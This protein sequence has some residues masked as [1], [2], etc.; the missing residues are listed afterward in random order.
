MINSAKTVLALL[1]TCLLPLV[2]QAQQHIDGYFLGNSLT[3][4]VRLAWLEAIVD[5]DNP[6]TLD[7]TE[8]IV[9]GTPIDFLYNNRTAE[10]QSTFDQGDWEVATLQPYLRNLQQDIA[11]V[12]NM[13]NAGLPQNPQIQFYIYAQ[14][15]VDNGFDYSMQWLQEVSNYLA[16]GSEAGRIQPQRTQMYY[17]AL[18]EAFR[19]EVASGGNLPDGANL[20]RMIPVGHLMFVIDQLIKAGEITELTST[21]DFLIGVHAENNGMF[22]AGMTFY[23]TLFGESP[24]GLP[25]EEYQGD[26]GSTRFISPQL[27][28]TIRR[29]A[30]GVVT[31]HP[32]AGVTG[33]EPVEMLLSEIHH[34]AVQGEPFR[35]PIMAGYGPLPYGFS[36]SAGNLPPGLSLDAATGWISGTPTSAGTYGFEVTVA[37]ASNASATE[38]YEIEVEPDV[39]VS[40]GTLDFFELQAGVMAK[41]PLPVIGGNGSPTWTLQS[42]TLPLGTLKVDPAGFLSGVPSIAGIYDVTLKVEDGDSENPESDTLNVRFL[43]TP[44]PS[45]V[46]FA[47]FMEDFPNIENLTHSS[48]HVKPLNL[49]TVEGE[50]QI[51]AS[52]LLG[53]R[54]KFL[55]GLAIVDDDN[56]ISDSSDYT[57]D[58]SVEFLIDAAKNVENEFNADDRRF[59]VRY[60]SAKNGTQA[61]GT[62]DPTDSFDRDEGHVTATGYNVFFSNRYNNLGGINLSAG[63]KVNNVPVN[64]FAADQGFG[65][66]GFDLQVNDD[67]DG[68]DRDRAGVFGVGYTEGPDQKNW[69]TAILTRLYLEPFERR[70]FWV[71][72][73]VNF[74]PKASFGQKPYTWS[75]P[76][77]PA[78]LSIDP[79]TGTISGTPTTADN[80]DRMIIRVTGSDG[81]FTEWNDFV[82]IHTNPDSDGDDLPDAW[83]LQHFGNL[84]TA[85][86]AS[87]SD[88]DSLSDAV[89]FVLGLDPS[90]P[91][92]WEM[93]AEV[94]TSDGSEWLVAR[95]RRNAEY[96]MAATDLLWRSDDLESWSKVDFDGLDALLFVRDPDV[97][98]DGSVELMEARIR[99]TSSDDKM[100][101]RLQPEIRY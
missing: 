85:N 74:Q 69:K 55:F 64:G 25:L 73:P 88:S 82:S 24:E 67:D 11:G 75:A 31:G 60:T 57:H 5:G 17:E 23:A 77:L 40:T 93:K 47:P 50:G 96:P 101:V 1:S 6:N 3:A 97:D 95:W 26:G 62:L 78:G 28:Q 81:W 84:T 59:I 7:V 15:P 61:Q 54:P 2:A 10:I 70:E 87:D 65:V 19:T 53:W 9:P 33:N 30:W 36:I 83:E 79:A 49:T 76:S 42:G 18:T 22:M 72:K 98:G 89:E 20:M 41:Q 39:S 43:V 100:F 94:V 4:N 86:A 16:T 80:R 71:G 46:I 27:A 13:L 35:F 12:T 44:P 63:Y 38:S 32:L 68:G 56:L 99:L 8:T 58:D 37:D 45:D 91:D 48:E 66:I 90:K 29:N 92:F 21:E 34:L 14:W 51:D 52:Y